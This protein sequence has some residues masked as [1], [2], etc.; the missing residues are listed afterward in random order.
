M[1]KELHIARLGVGAWESQSHSSARESYFLK[2]LA[3]GIE[4]L[5][6]LR[7]SILCKQH[8]LS[9]EHIQTPRE[10]ASHVEPRWLSP[11]QTTYSRSRWQ[12]SLE[13]RAP[14]PQP[15]LPGQPSRWRRNFYRKEPLITCNRILKSLQQVR[16]D[17]TPILRTD[18]TYCTLRG[19]NLAARYCGSY[20]RRS[21]WTSFEE[22]QQRINHPKL[23]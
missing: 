10:A 13:L 22:Q 9:S 12:P 14:F 2:F 16:R 15:R 5:N 11:G 3:N 19:C 4:F 23:L 8:H 17:T 6:C 18:S 21:R 20:R 1:L 7:P